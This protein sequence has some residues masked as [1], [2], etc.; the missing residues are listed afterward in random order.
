MYLPH[1]IAAAGPLWR[2]AVDESSPEA[3]GFWVA[4]ALALVLIAIALVVP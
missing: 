4:A 2:Q 3:A 1:I